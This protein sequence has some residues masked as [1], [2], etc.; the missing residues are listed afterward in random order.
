MTRLRYERL[1]HRTGRRSIRLPCR[2]WEWSRA[3]VAD[4]RSREEWL[5][6][7]E[8]ADESRVVSAL[9]DACP[10]SGSAALYQ[11]FMALLHRF[12]KD[13][14]PEVRRVALHLE[15]D[16]L[17]ALRKE[18]EEAAGWVRNPP[19]GGGRRGRIRRVEIRQGW[20]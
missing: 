13:A 9:H 6:D 18:D 8:S 15:V 2:C 4:A 3:R 14:R 10:C 20:R 16:A 11:E 19:G 12:K 7:I 5:A 17:D 1:A